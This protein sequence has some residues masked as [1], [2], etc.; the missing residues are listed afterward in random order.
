MAILMQLV[1]GVVAN[2]FEISDKKLTI[3]RLPQND[4]IIDD[5][6]VSSSH[7]VVECVPNPDFPE[8][9]EYF[10]KDLGSTNGTELN[11]NA[12]TLQAQLHHNDEIK[13]AFNIFKFLDEQSVN[14]S[15]TVHIL[16]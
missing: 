5:S 6:S 8:V 10:V 16:K 1:D 15:K 9:V 14:L 4:I 12:L 7:A 3:G 2:K 11:G 13:I